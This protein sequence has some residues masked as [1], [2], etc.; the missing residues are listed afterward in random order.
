MGEQAVK[1]IARPVRVFRI[2][3][4]PNATTELLPAVSSKAPEAAPQAGGQDTP[5]A[6]LASDEG[7]MELAFWSSVQSSGAPLEYQAYLDRYPQGAFAALAHARLENS[8]APLVDPEERQ[9][10]LAFWDTVKSS[11]NP[12]MLRAYL[13]RFPHGEFKV[14]ADLRL[15]ELGKND[16][17][18]TG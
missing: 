13:D 6:T 18:S 16:L 17:P 8:E 4:D 1:N 9:I 11:D 14:L 15:T 12:A 7:A 3:F 10:E 5:D 2:M